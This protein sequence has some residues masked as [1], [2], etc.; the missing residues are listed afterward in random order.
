MA[1]TQAALRILRVRGG[2]SLARS[3]LS[4]PPLQLLDTL[5]PLRTRVSV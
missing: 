5:A 1:R 2:R 3:Q 4:A